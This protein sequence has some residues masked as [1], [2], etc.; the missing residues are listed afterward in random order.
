MDIQMPMSD[1]F[2]IV[3][4]GLTIVFSALV[5]LIIFIAVIGLV[6]KKNKNKDTN[7]TL[8]E[9]TKATTTSNNSSPAIEEGISDEVVAVIAAAIA[10]MSS[11]SNGTTYAIHAIKRATTGRP[12]W[13]MAGLQEN[14]RAF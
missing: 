12:A 13:A 14:T 4:T 6:F 3:F 9:T 10:A 7:K 2:A 11:E 1:T 5:L 8:K